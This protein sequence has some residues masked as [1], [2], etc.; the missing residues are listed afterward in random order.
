MRTLSAIAAAVL[1]A[2]SLAAAEPAPEVPKMSRADAEKYLDE[3]RLSV[4]GSNLVGPIM[5][6]DA[7]TVEALLSAGV[8]VNDTGALPKPVM[9]LAMQP[10]AMKDQTTEQMLTMIEVLLAHGAKVNEPPG[11][12]LTPLIVAAQ[13]CPAPIVK[14]LIAAGAEVDYKNTLG[15]TALV[16]ALIMSNYEA[17]EALIGGGAKLSAEGA[18]K[19]LENKKD[20]PKLAELVK[21][22]RGEK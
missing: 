14:R 5:N 13:H 1:F 4:T 20:D 10:C 11:A 9:R 21:K 22:A 17:A 19:L 2:G 7:E 8:D 18:A 15:Q 3:R 16:N 12:V 6:G